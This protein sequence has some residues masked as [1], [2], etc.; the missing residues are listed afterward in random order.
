M[1]DPMPNPQELTLKR[2]HAEGQKT[3]AYFRSLGE[4]DYAQQV[5][6][7]GPGWRVRDVLAHFVSAE[8]TFVFYGR[9]ILAGG[10]GAPDDFVID[11]FNATQVAGL[12]DTSPADLVGQ[13]EAARAETLALVRGMQAEDFGRIGR[14]PWFGRVP[15][16]QML[17][18]IYRHNMLHERDVRRA[19]ETG[20]PVPHVD[21]QPVAD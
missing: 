21:A 11:E 3:A 8:Q 13:F 12:K 5:Y 19:L 16:E 20:Q 10:P 6:T 7:T 9:D 1:E 18:L 17:K 4:A 14:H 15:L 2:L